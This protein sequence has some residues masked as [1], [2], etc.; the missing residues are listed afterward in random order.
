[1]SEKVMAALVIIVFA[2]LPI[3]ATAWVSVKNPTQISCIDGFW[4]RKRGSQEHWRS[5]TSWGNPQRCV[6]EPQMLKHRK[7]G[8]DG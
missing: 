3:G 2:V 8:S 4:Y 6:V 7:G 5:I 1:M